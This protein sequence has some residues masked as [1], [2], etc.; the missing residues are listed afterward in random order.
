MSVTPHLPDDP[1]E[2]RRLLEDLLRRNDELRQQAEA[3]RTTGRGRAAAGRRRPP[4]HRRTG[5]HP[6][7]RPPPT[8]TA[9]RRSTP[10]WLETLALLRRYLFGPR[11][12]RF[13]RRPGPRPSLRSPR[14]LAEPEPAR[15][16]P[17]RRRGAAATPPGPPPAA[18]P[19]R[20]S[21]AHPHR[22]RPHRGRE[23]L[24]LL[25]RPQGSASARTSPASSSSSRPG[26]RSTSTSCPSTPARSAA[27]AWPARRSRPSPS[28]AAS[29]GPGWSP[30]WSSASSPITCRSI[31]SKIS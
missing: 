26:W 28:R 11:R 6:R 15:A 22:A 10:S 27:T 16:R 5:A 18:R 19:L 25:R 23:D 7:R 17:G 4:P 9:S 30:S 29:P 31:D 8:T 24:L 14:V 20:A 1:A 3:D 21:P 13:A 2:C 12:E